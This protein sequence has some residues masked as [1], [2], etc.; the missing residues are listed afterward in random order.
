MKKFL[1]ILL[2]FKC[3]CD[4]STNIKH[5]FTLIGKYEIANE[6]VKNYFY[7]GNVHASWE[8]AREVCKIFE[9]QLISFKNPMEEENFRGKFGKFFKGRDSF[10]FIGANTSTP[11]SKNN[12]KWL[13]GEKLNFDIVWGENQPNNDGNRESCLCFDENDPLLYHDISCKEKYP[14]VCEEVWN[15]ERILVKKI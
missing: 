1:L 12:W 15:Y 10:I 7:S 11:G 4:T 3:Y 8:M 14:F 2:V 9:M 5:P 13:N 6:T